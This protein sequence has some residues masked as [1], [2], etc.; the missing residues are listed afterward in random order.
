MKKIENRLTKLEKAKASAECVT[1]TYGDGSETEMDLLQAVRLLLD[2]TVRII[3]RPWKPG[4]QRD[5]GDK[6]LAEL[7]QY[8]DEA[9]ERRAKKEL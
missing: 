5:H 2:G 9:R 1:A 3:T 8:M 7:E 6:V 4:E